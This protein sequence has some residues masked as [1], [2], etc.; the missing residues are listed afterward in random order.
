MKQSLKDLANTVAVILVSPVILLHML[1]KLY[2]NEGIFVTASQFLSLM[3]GDFGSYLRVAFYRFAMNR[4]SS[5]CRISFATI[6]SQADTEISTGVYIGAQCN[7]GKCSIGRDSMIASGVHIMSGS[8]QHHTDDLDQPM[9]QQG[10]EF[11][12][13]E[14]GED[15]WIGNGALIMANVGSKSVI[16]AG[17]VV[18]K[19]IP[20]YS[21][22][23]GNPAKV[24]RSRNQDD[25]S[26][27]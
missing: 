20:E 21:I 2:C 11:V 9:Q 16:G 27:E 6:F 3:P 26:Q 4:C 1:A 23:V 14:I 25:E 19:D 5:D 18:T 24:V 13:I 22:A 10:G 12:K 7:I 8:R 15:C 17:A